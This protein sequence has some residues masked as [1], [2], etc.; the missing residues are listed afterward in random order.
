MNAWGKLVPG[1]PNRDLDGTA[2]PGCD[3]QHQ[4]IDATE[5]AVI[6]GIGLAI[7]EAGIPYSLVR[8]GDIVDTTWGC[9]RNRKMKTR[10][11]FIYEIEVALVRNFQSMFYRPQLSYCAWHIGNN[12]EPI[13]QSGGM[14]LTQFTCPK[15]AWEI[16]PGDWLWPSYKLEWISPISGKSQRIPGRGVHF[17]REK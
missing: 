5:L 13:R 4:T 14:A 17:I 1:Y 2:H 9:D 15:G 16:A 11:A 7:L 8:A 6:E 10:K 3:H 12:G